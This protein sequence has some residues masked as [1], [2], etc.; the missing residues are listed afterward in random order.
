MKGTKTV[1][2]VWEKNH[3]FQPLIL[4]KIENYREYMV[5]RQ[6]IWTFFKRLP[7][8]SIL[9]LQNKCRFHICTS[10]YE[11][12][13]HYIHEAKSA[14]AVIITTDAPPMNEFITKDMGYHVAVAGTERY[15]LGTLSKISAG[16]LER[17]IK[18]TMG[19][20]EKELDWMGKAAR[21]SF[22]DNDKFFRS[23]LKSIFKNL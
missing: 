20:N 2:N 12:F 19:V 7:E 23:T 17:V 4:G 14:G 18:E 15:N 6:N 21:Q 1:F 9:Q 10:E 3:D 22:V 13:G 16:S 8:S 11:G 5:S